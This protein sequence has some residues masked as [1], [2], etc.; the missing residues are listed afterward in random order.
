[1]MVTVAAAGPQRAT[2]SGPVVSSGSPPPNKPIA[3]SKQASFTARAPL[4]KLLRCSAAFFKVVSSAAEQL[5]AVASGQLM[6]A[7]PAAPMTG[8]VGALEYG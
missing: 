4:K 3:Q 7:A 8:L 1:M 6:Q 5:F 2:A